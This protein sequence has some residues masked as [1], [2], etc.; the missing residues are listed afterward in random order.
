MLYRDFD[1]ATV[2][3]AVEMAL[4]SG[5]SSGEAVRHLVKP[6]AGKPEPGKLKCWPSFPQPDIS[7]YT[8]LGGVL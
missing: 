7:D 5:V 2:S 6:P 3:E 1:P 8:K 4:I